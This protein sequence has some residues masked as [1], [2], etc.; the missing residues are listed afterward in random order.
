MREMSFLG[1]AAVAAFVL[2]ACGGGDE[3]S[4]MPFDEFEG[5]SMQNPGEPGDTTE[6]SGTDDTQG[7]PVDGAP[8]D[9][10]EGMD[11]GIDIAP[12]EPAP[13]DMLPDVMLPP[14]V[15]YGNGRLV[16]GA[17]TLVCLDDSTDPDAAG[18]VDGWGFEQNRSC[19]TPESTLAVMNMPCDIPELIPLP[20]LPPQIPAAPI[21]RPEGTLSRGFYVANGRLL[22][23]SGNDFVMRG[24]NHPV[25]WFQASSLEWMDE[26]ATTGAN[27]VRIVWEAT[28]QDTAPVRAAIERAVELS[29]VPMVELHDVTG[30]TDLTGPARMAQYYVDEMRDILIEFEPYLLVNIC[31]EW[32][33][34][35]TLDADWVAAYQAAITVLRDNGINHTL[36]IDANNYGQRG[37]TIVANGA[38]MLDFDP[39]HNLLFSTHMYEG[40]ANPQ[41]ILD[42]IRGAQAA[43]LPLIVGE[44]GFQHGQGVPVRVPFE[45]MIEEAERVGMGYLPWSWT[46]NNDVVG[47]L[48]MSVDGSAANLTDW[49]DD[50]INGTFGIRSTSKLASIFTSL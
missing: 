3:M 11:P 16:N 31:N 17:C 35:Q 34:F 32:G 7:P 28:Q 29:M 2:A 24:I 36:V 15:L 6:P 1:Q 14:G 18:M 44:F 42:V 45:V 9:S 21:P 37:S 8:T 43:S 19:L 10:N 4:G 46:G 49:G 41:T 20:P 48:D 30:S 22:D 5:D 39:Q 26:I 33:A 50:I 23:S 12:T 13:T 38:A 27:S 25:A 40:Y 47:Y